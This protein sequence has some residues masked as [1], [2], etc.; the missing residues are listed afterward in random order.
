MDCYT[1]LVTIDEQGHL[2]YN[3]S[4]YDVKG[5]QKWKKEFKIKPQ[6]MDVDGEHAY[7]DDGISDDGERSYINYCDEEDS[8]ILVVFDSDGKEV[9]N[10]K[11]DLLLQDIEISPDGK[12]VGAVTNVASVK[13]LFFLDVD[14]SKT[15]LVKAETPHL[16]LRAYVLTKKT[17]QLWISNNQD[18]DKNKII[19]IE[20]SNLPSD[21][22]ELIKGGGD[23]K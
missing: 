18:Y 4:L 15:K 2:N 10:A 7:W 16:S 6:Y 20:F 8:Y 5:N 11:H 1:P 3:V 13:Y 23:G 9:A 17:I 21:M 14:T 12:L 22:A 19:D